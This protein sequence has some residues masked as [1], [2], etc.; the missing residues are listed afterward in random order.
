MLSQSVKNVVGRCF[1][2]SAYPEPHVPI[3]T[4]SLEHSVIPFAI[5]SDRTSENGAPYPLS[6]VG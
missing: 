6:L 4:N 1:Y 2:Y 3:K 5:H